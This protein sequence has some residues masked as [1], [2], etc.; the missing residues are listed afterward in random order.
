MCYDP[1][2]MKVHIC[3]DV[4]FE[5]G[6]KWD[7]KANANDEGQFHFSLPLT[8][9][10]M[11]LTRSHLFKE[12]PLQE[13]MEEVEKIMKKSLPRKKEINKGGLYLSKTFMIR[14]I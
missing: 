9:R 1:S 4:L 8:S 7:W 12:N 11:T 3:R 6:S 10:L 13:K 14:L 5:E 2:I